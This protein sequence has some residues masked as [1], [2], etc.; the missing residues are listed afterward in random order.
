MKAG[1]QDEAR[2]QT[3][4]FFESFLRVQLARKSSLEDLANLIDLFLVANML[5]ESEELL[6]LKIITRQKFGLEQR[7][8]TEEQSDADKLRYVRQIQGLD[9][10][11]V[12]FSP[13]KLI[14]R[15]QG[16]DDECIMAVS[17]VGHSKEALGASAP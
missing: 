3:A 17:K 7:D 9:S 1:R 12:I 4:K 14:E 15:Y 2:L 13:Q 11:Y 8:Q 10:D 6:K 16:R 5:E